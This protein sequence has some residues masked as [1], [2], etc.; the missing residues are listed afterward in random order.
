MDRL[1]APL[2]MRLGCKHSAKMAAKDAE[3]AR[4]REGLAFYAQERNWRAAGMYM[5]GHAPDSCC[6]LDG[7]KRARA[8]LDAKP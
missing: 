5:C 6:A 3:I 2:C 8:A 4:L 1:D 7:G